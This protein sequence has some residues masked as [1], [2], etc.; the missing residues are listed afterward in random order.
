MLFRR[1]VYT[2]TFIPEDL[3]AYFLF[4]FPLKSSFQDL[5][6][7]RIRNEDEIH[8]YIHVGEYISKTGWYSSETCW[9]SSLPSGQMPLRQATPHW[10]P[11]PKELEGKPLGPCPTEQVQMR[12]MEAS[13]PHPCDNFAFVSRP[14]SHRHGP[15]PA[16]CTHSHVFPRLRWL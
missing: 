2:M 10:P 14:P 9:G 6:W 5:S 7:S 15:A 11:P 12:P 1:Y 13:S 4:L 16:T 8:I 3:K